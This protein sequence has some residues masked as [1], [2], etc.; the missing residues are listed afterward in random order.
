VA[1]DEKVAKLSPLQ[2][3]VLGCVAS[4]GIGGGLGGAGTSYLGGGVSAEA[5]G[6]IEKKIDALVVKADELSDDVAATDR[7]SLERDHKQGEVIAELRDRVTR[8]EVE[9][10]NLK[11]AK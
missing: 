6:R 4:L 5:V 11:K 10:E 7:L 9:L 1:D 3:L 2:Q 8:L